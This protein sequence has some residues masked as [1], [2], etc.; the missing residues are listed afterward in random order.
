M[1]LLKRNAVLT[2]P[3]R[4]AGKPARSNLFAHRNAL[5]L[6][7]LAVAAYV[8]GLFPIEWRYLWD[9]AVYL[10]IAENLFSP[11][12]YYTEINFRPPLFPVL[13]HFGP[14]V[15]SIDLFARLLGAAFFTAGVLLLFLFGSRLYGY[16]PGLWAA[17]LMLFSP[18]FIFWS[19]KVMVDIPGTVLLLG[20]MY[21]LFWHAQ[22]TH[23]RAWSAILAGLLLAASVLMRWVCGLGGICALYFLVTRR[24]NFRSA[25]WY[26]AGFLIAMAPYLAW[27][28]VRQ[29]SFWKPLL[30]WMAVVEQG[31]EP[32][33]DK[34]YYLKGLFMI[35][36][37]VALFGLFC[38]FFMVMLPARPRGWLAVDLPLLLW[39]LSLLVFLNSVA[40]K[41]Y[42]DILP[43]IPALYLLSGRGF[44][45][46]RHE[47]LASVAVVALP[48]GMYYT[49][50]H[51]SYFQGRE[52]WIATMLD[53]SGDTRDAGEF[54]KANIPP[55]TVVY[56]NHLW[57][58]LAYYSKRKTIA[59]FPNDER[60]YRWYPK[61]MKEDGY[62]TYYTGVGKRPDLGWLDRRPE[63]H[64]ISEFGSVILYS[65]KYPGELPP[66]PE[67]VSLLTEARA[68][69][70]QGA[71]DRV[72][73]ILGPLWIPDVDV[74]DL[75]GWS[76][77]RMGKIDEAMAAFH[78]GLR[79]EPY[80]PRCLTGLG[81]CELRSGDVKMAEEHF[82]AAVDQVP[83]KLDAI[84]GLGL[85]ELRLG[86]KSEAADQFRN[87]LRLHPNDDDVKAYLKQTETP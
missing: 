64:K 58:V 7:V 74:G 26:G 81:Y 17:I 85:A 47:L 37:P 6:I 55:N 24:I 86:N 2:V 41:E 21:F 75:R 72:V 77:Y 9:E 8:L 59:V 19:H 73:E 11:A 35:L 44:S 63:F 42:R 12:P 33:L 66:D 23:Q 1:S 51:L 70:E 79:S 65:Y 31:S 52:Q 22:D 40:H 87:A 30:T 34:L 16:W 82:K 57:P 60:F 54:L 15:M 45:W 83:D 25:V 62:F 46:L 67:Y 49:V 28:H 61:N 48:I 36:G 5:S 76:Y 3:E 4:V 14:R 38:Y 84:V 13:L 29:G 32:V 10:S 18:F 39:A 50:A 53:Y 43:T 20:S 56:S 69:F 27:A 71:Y 78:E 68:Q 80:N